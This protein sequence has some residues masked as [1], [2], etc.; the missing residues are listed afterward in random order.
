MNIKRIK[1]MLVATLSATGLPTCAGV[2]VAE[3]PSKTEIE[4]ALNAAY[5]KY[6]TL[7][8][9]KNA[10]YIPALAKVDSKIYGIALVNDGKIYTAGDVTSE[11]SIQSIS[12]VFIMAKV[13]EESGPQ[14]IAENI[15]VDATGQVFNS[16]VA[17]EQYRGSEMN[18]M[19]NAG[20][21][22]ATSMV[23]SASAEEIW[24]KI[25]AYYDDFAGRP[26]S[27][28]EEVYKSEASTNQRNQ[29]IASLMYA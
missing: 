13:I 7:Q 11:V 17:V 28:N 12:K 22:T 18:A 19:V 16:I 21:I 23:K 6:Q 24:N 14:S 25:I 9:G 10:D 5:E 15:G 29:A 20:T 8:E 2:A 27:V 26:L 3:I 1:G 4:A